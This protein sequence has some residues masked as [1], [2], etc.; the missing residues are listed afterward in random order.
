MK[1]QIFG[2]FEV[3]IARSK[4]EKRLFLNIKGGGNPHEM[5]FSISFVKIFFGV[6][7]MDA[8]YKIIVDRIVI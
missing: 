3:M 8:F 6:K 5:Y 4:D 2:S 7:E 1:N